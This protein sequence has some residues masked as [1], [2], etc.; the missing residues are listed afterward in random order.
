MAY[1]LALG[2]I[3]FLLAVI[4]GHPLINLLRQWGIGKGIRIHRTSC[5]NANEMMRRYPYRVVKSNWTSKG[6]ASYQAVL[7]ITGDDELGMV[8]N[9]SEVISKDLRV[10]MRSISVDSSDGGFEGNLTVYVANTDHLNKLINKLKKIKGVHKV[11][12]YDTVA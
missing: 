11:S 9:I 6:A 2:T 7:H 5:P 8:T 10:Q 12:R 4:W 1:S 3:T